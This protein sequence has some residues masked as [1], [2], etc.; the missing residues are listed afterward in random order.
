V[1]RIAKSINQTITRIRNLAAKELDLM[2]G[3]VQRAEDSKQKM[4]EELEDF[5]QNRTIEA[6][7]ARFQK[8][9]NPD[10]RKKLIQMIDLYLS[11][12][13]AIP[14]QETYGIKDQGAGAEIV[15]QGLEEPTNIPLDI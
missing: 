14:K 3:E 8:I 13:R 10:E 1:K 12:D 7:F 5:K 15:L 4:A 11:E 9:P 2:R 6:Y